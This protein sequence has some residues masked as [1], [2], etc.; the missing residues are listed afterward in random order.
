MIPIEILELKHN[1]EDRDWDYCSTY[2]MDKNEAEKII[3]AI[4]GL[5]TRNKGRWINKS[6][7][8]GSGVD[9]LCFDCSVCEKWHSLPSNYC[10]HC[11]AKM[12]QESEG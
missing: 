5:Q 12:V 8:S 2:K 7:K 10:P 6:H 11:G 3:K 9:F 1:L 4:D